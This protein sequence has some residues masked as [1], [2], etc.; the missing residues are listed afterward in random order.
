MGYMG[1]SLE[2]AI[3][4]FAEDE[5]D[6]QDHQDAIDRACVRIEKELIATVERVLTLADWMDQALP[7]AAEQGIG[8][9]C[10]EVKQSGYDAFIDLMDY[11]AVRPALQA[12]IASPAGAALRR[13][14]AKAHAEAQTDGLA[15]ARVK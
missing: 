15:S 12:L 6:A 4:Q 2:L 3:D 13:E 1:T 8:F 5:G 14:L 11:K 7:A 9:P 10:K